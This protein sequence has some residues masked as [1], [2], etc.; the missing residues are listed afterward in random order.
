[1]SAACPASSSDSSN[2]FSTLNHHFQYLAQ[3]CATSNRCCVTP[4]LPLIMLILL[5]GLWGSDPPNLSGHLNSARHMR[6]PPLTCW[7]Y[8]PYCGAPLPCCVG[9]CQVSKCYL[10]SVLF[11]GK[12][13]THKQRWK[14]FKGTWLTICNLNGLFT[15]KLLLLNGQHSSWRQ[16]LHAV[17]AIIKKT[18]FSHTS[19]IMTHANYSMSCAHSHLLS[20]DM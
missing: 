6:A 13:P 15:C 14:W 1:M 10:Q 9:M 8:G 12:S 20:C 17:S 3:K 11:H 19:I 2:S 18:S 4:R 16:P 7:V 5:S